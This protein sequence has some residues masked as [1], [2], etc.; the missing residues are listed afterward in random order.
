M[1]ITFDPEKDKLNRRKHGVSLSRAVEFEWQHAVTWLDQRFEYGESRVCALGMIGG[2]LHFM[3][4][5]EK[6][7]VLRIISLR[8]ANAN[9]ERRYA[10][11][12]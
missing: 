12:T 5:V 8:K 3:V 11:T 2:R 7:G 1:E 6:N 4:F 10:G 9:E